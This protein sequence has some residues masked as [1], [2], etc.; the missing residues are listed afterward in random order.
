MTSTTAPNNADATALLPIGT[1]S[2]Q[3]GVNSVTLRAW[4]RRYGLL[5]PRR[6]PKGHRL[7]SQH[8]VERVKQVLILLDQGIPVSRVRDV[9]DSHHPLP[10]LRT[11]TDVKTDDPWRHYHTLFQRWIRKLDARSLDQVFNEAVS[12]YSLELVAKKLLL[13]L[14]Q[15][16]WQ[17]QALLPST[18]ADYA[19][20][21]EFLCAKLSARYLQH[22]SRATGKRILLANQHDNTTQVE[23]LLLANVLSQHGYQVSLLGANT[24]LDHL[25][26][27]LER[28][29]LDALVLPQSSGLSAALHALV[30]LTGIHVFL[31]G[32]QEAQ[33][34][35]TEHARIHWL[36]DEL[37]D[38]CPLMD[39]VLLT[40]GQTA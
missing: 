24:Q 18:Y 15:Q 40:A 5:K 22:N 2:E 39:Q 26:L 23:L 12:L 38:I 8:D 7:Y 3:T 31:A 30:A 14:H 1:V 19:F 6:T 21:H 37:N 17:Q 16:L 32:I 25:P 10:L 33:A 20:L 11:A 27:I 28:A 4:E 9:L 29:A 36:P 34:D 35:D 13:P